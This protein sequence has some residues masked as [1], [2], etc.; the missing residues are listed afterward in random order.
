MDVIYLKDRENV[1]KAEVREGENVLDVLRREH[2]LIQAPCNGRGTCGKCRIRIHGEV[3]E[4]LACQTKVVNQMHI[5]V[6]H[7]GEGMDVLSEYLDEKQGMVQPQCGDRNETYV[8]AIDLGTTTV[9]IQ[10][11][12]V[13]Q[14]T[15]I[16]RKIQTIRSL[17]PQSVYGADVISRI[18]AAMDGKAK[19]LKSCI[20]RLLCDSIEAMC[21][22]QGIHVPDIHEI[23]IGGNTTML[24]LLKGYDVHGLS[25]HPFEPVTLKME[26]FP[27]HQ[28]SGGTVQEREPM[29]TLL[30]G[31]S[32]FVGSDITAGIYLLGLERKEEVNLF[33]D[34]GTNGEIAIGNR[35]RIIATSTAAGPAF[36]GGN[37][38]CGIGSLPGAVSEVV[39][40]KR[41]ALCKTIGN[42]PAIGLCGT[43]ALEFLSELWSHGFLDSHGTFLDEKY[44]KNGYPLVLRGVDLKQPIVLT[45][46]DIRQ[47]Q[48]AKSAIRAGMEVLLEEY[49]VS[50]DEVEHLYIAGGMGF[51]L[52]LTKAAA[53][54]LV[55]PQMIE[56]VQVVGNSCLGGCIQYLKE[57]SQNIVESIVSKVEHIQLAQ[58]SRFTDKYVK[59]MDF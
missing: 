54:G 38:S 6:V 59:Y 31:I 15:K 10:L 37:L 39:L 25:I 47:L 51:G 45:Q 50:W 9:V 52:N 27:Y 21:H 23:V 2:M 36:E 17:N 49:G 5:E 43:G 41:Y 40:K 19:E 7:S 4:R 3:Q 12:A 32:A 46:E 44:R 57:K 24:H 53:I 42:R 14:K 35:H 16:Y 33:V 28:L 29:V 13:D 1:I 34:L 22:T 58:D 56:K 55:P 20:T 18:T 48:L 30:P 11:G 26:S 8:I